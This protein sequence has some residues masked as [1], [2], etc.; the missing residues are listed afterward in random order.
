MIRHALIAL[1]LGLPTAT[2]A[3]LL[4]VDGKSRVFPLTLREDRPMVTA[5]VAGR[6]GVVMFDIGTPY[7][8]MLNRDALD[9]PEGQEVARGH[10]ASGQEIVVMRHRAPE[11]S[12]AG[13]V[14]ALPENLL[15]GNFGF[16]RDGL[17]A[18]FL[19]FLGLPAVADTPFVLDLDRGRL[20]LLQ[21]APEPVMALARTRIDPSGGHLPGWP[22]QVGPFPIRF[23]IDTGDG[24]TFYATEET[25]AALEAK[26]LL[27]KA[28][29]GTRLSEVT[30]GGGLFGPISVRVVTAGGPED[31][32][33]PARGDLVRLGASFLTRYPTLWDL[34]GGTITVLPTDA[35]L[36]SELEAIRP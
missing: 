35:P 21:A 7:L 30:F 12:L 8:L 13:E 5:E 24:G 16:T 22:G 17:G 11:V 14:L 10:A 36:L 25:R 2:Q 28:A 19:G 3:D 18:D 33:E 27:V 20:T 23:D 1:F 9:L 4:S 6:K 34:P 29:G 31:M 32:R 26:G 15:S